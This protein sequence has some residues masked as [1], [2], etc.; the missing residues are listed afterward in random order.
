MPPGLGPSG[1][2]RRSVVWFVAAGAIL[3][4]FAVVIV[5]ATVASGLGNLFDFELPER[6]HLDPV[7]IAAS[8][9]PYVVLMHQAANNSQVSVPPLGILGYDERGQRLSWPQARARMMLTADALETSIAGSRPHL[10]APVRR[11]LA[12]ALREIRSGR[13]Q[14]LLARD[15]TD[16]WS[17]TEDGLERGKLAFGYASDLVGR[18]CGVP[19]GADDAS[20]PYPF[21]TR[22]WRA[23]RNP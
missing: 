10:P 2:S 14:L 1:P 7:P 5:L 17:R 4:P 8:A 3:A 11:Q 9:C 12:V 15:G 13:A 22:P 20:M 6:K 21:G 19:L 16:F 18:R 23:T